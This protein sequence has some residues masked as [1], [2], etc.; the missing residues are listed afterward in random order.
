[1]KVVLEEVV[2]RIV[3][4]IPTYAVIL[5]FSGYV[6]WAKYLN[7]RKLKLKG[8][9]DLLNIFLIT[10]MY[11]SVLY[12]FVFV[13]F[14]I[15]NILEGNLVI[16]PSGSQTNLIL[17]WT[18]LFITIV[19]VLYTKVEKGS[20]EDILQNF[21]LANR[22]IFVISLIFG[23][24]IFIPYNYLIKSLLFLVFISVSLLMFTEI[25]KKSM[26]VVKKNK[27]KKISRLTRYKGII[28]AATT[29]LVLVLILL[30][31]LI[32]Y[33]LPQ[34]QIEI[35]ENQRYHIT[36]STGA[37]SAF[38]EEIIY[39]N[40]TKEKQLKKYLNQIVF[41]MQK[42]GYLST[43]YTRKNSNLKAMHESKDKEKTC[44]YITKE[45]CVQGSV[46]DNIDKAGVTKKGGL[47]EGLLVLELD[48]E[49]IRKEK[50]K[51]VFFSVFKDVELK[52][53]N[54]SFLAP[55]HDVNCEEGTC[56]ITL[57]FKNNLNLPV[58]QKETYATHHLQTY[59]DDPSSCRFNQGSSSIE[60]QNKDHNIKIRNINCQDTYCHIYLYEENTPIANIQLG[61]K[62]NER[63]YIKEASFEKPLHIK[64]NTTITCNYTENNQ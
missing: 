5:L 47:K 43:F 6:T 22:I 63:V 23:I 26:V 21:V 7:G 17:E 52:K 42:E 9:G 40:I 16:F 32:N 64:I 49:K 19:I 20:F 58:I 44:V 10:C 53:E 57:I 41:E 8:T 1:M 13:T 25:F 24:L 61:I 51:G 29:I 54:Y 62:S 15:A 12:N 37:S 18:S 38:L 48:Y 33:Y 28:I 60:N 45:K 3:D 2:G 46:T 4:I 36:D 31:G 34:Y 30:P 50:L 56:S 39:I 35:F 59:L 27:I 14:S 11:I 55:H